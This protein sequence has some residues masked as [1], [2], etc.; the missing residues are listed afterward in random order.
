M[1]LSLAETSSGAIANASRLH[2]TA[3][4][5]N[6]ELL[7]DG[8]EQ[9]ALDFL[10][11]RPL[12]TICLTGLILDNGITSPLNRGSFYAYRNSLGQVEGIALI[13]HATLLEAR[14]DAAIEAFARLA[15]NNLRAHLIRAEQ[16]VIERFLCYY[17]QAECAPRLV[18]REMLLEQRQS[19]PVHEAVEALRPVT[20]DDLELVMAVNARMIYEE[21]SVNPLE[22]DLAGFRQRTALRIER[23]RVWAVIEKGRLIFKTEVMFMTP[24]VTYLEGVYLDPEMRSKGFGFR[25]FSQ[26]CQHL[27]A[28][29]N[30]LCLLVNETNQAAINLYFRAGYTERGFYDT[31]YLQRK[32]S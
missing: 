21:C 27:H 24:E 6:P 19:G 28:Q 17:T 30:S 31:I 16:E 32:S 13:G 25:C 3:A 12:H 5:P 22:S 14:S 20:L 11:P 29:T 10:A 9:E 2:S 8:H 23:E 4:P 7:S 18:C 26:L 15:Q 1:S